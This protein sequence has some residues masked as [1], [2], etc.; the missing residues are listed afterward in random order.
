[1]PG[2]LFL[3]TSVVVRY[4]LG[5]P[6]DLAARAAEIIEE[7]DDLVLSELALVEAAYVLQSVYEVA[8]PR[9]LDALTLFVQRRNVRLLNLPKSSALEAL[10]LCRPSGLHSFTDALLWAQARHARASAIAT[11][12][13]RFPA[14]GVRLIDSPA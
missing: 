5:E 14:E 7:A 11:F 8:R 1:M 13:R 3:D 10:E 6:E 9:L 4:L 2:D 12:D